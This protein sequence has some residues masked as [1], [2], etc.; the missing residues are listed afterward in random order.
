MDDG[1]TNPLVGVIVVD[2]LTYTVAYWKTWIL[3]ESGVPCGTKA[4]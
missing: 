2:N 3:F 4:F 1:S